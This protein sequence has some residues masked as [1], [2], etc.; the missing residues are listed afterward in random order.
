MSHHPT[1]SILDSFSDLEDPRSNHTRLHKLIDIIVIPICAVICGADN[2]VEIEAYGNAKIEW[3]R[4]FLELPK[5]AIAS[6]IELAS[7]ARDQV[8]EYLI[9]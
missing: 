1:A 5:V 2:W 8:P 4:T 7:L 9:L 3:L 6:L